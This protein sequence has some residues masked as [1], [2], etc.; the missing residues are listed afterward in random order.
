[1]PPRSR[2][3]QPRGM[4]GRMMPQGPAPYPY[5]KQM[6]GRGGGAPARNG[7]GGILSK[8]L[9]G[10]KGGDTNS[11]QRG[12]G[13]T[14]GAGTRNAAAAGGGGILKTLTNP[15]SIN[16]FLA[17]SQK[18]LSTASQVGP[19]IS[20]Y[21]PMVRNIPAMWKLYKGLSSSSSDSTENEAKTKTINRTENTK[22]VGE[23]AVSSNDGA[24]PTEIPEATPE[25]GPQEGGVSVPRMYI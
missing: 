8:L 22:T 20:Q 14:F 1:M 19:M 12:L 11:A 10:G 16:G 21:G 2:M 23:T 3:P 15:A 4:G 25:S 5:Q 9:G 6:M 18:F 24:V 13:A 7:G 17:N